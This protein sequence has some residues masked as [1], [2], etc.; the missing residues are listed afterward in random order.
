MGRI[1]SIRRNVRN[2]S[3]CTIH[4]DGD[5][6][7]ACALDVALALG[8]RV[9]ME[10]TPEIASTL[11]KEDARLVL[12]QKGWRYASYKPRTEQQVRDH[13]RK[14]DV[15]QQEIDDLIA[16]LKDF[17][18]IDDCGYAQRF[19]AASQ[20]R[21]PLSTADARRRLKA[22]GLDSDVIQAALDSRTMD[23]EIKAALHVAERKLR[24]LHGSDQRDK[25]VRFL[26]YRGF[27]WTV[28]R[29]VLETLTIT[30]VLLTVTSMAQA[31][32]CHRQRLHPSVNQWQP[33]AVPVL[34]PDGAVLYIDRKNHPDN[35]DG[36]ADNDDVWL[37]RRGPDGQWAAPTREAITS[38][39]PRPD[40]LFH[41]TQDNL[42]ALVVG[43]YGPSASRAVAILTRTSPQA[44][45]TVV[46]LVMPPNLSSIEGRF[47]GTMSDDGR[48]VIL[49]LGRGRV[50]F[51]GEA[52][53]LDLFVTQ[54]CSTAWSSLLEISALNSR[55]FEGAP[56]LAPDGQTLYFASSGREPKKGKADLYIVRK[57]G[58]SW[59]SWTS[60][61]W[62]G[63][64][65]NTG[66]DETALTLHPDNTKATIVSWDAESDQPG[67]YDV[68]LAL[69]HRPLPWCAVTGT[70][71]E[72]RSGDL[73]PTAVV[74]FDDGTTGCSS[75]V[76][77][78]VDD[79]AEFL[80][81]LP[82]KSSYTIR[83][84]APG[85]TESHQTLTLRT[86][87]STLA[88]RQ[89][90]RLFRSDE[91]LASLYFERGTSSVSDQHRSILRSL[92]DTFGLRNVGFA[93]TG[94]ADD[95]GRRPFN[96]T[97]SSKRA[98]A[99]KEACIELGI[100]ED[101][102]IAIG[103][104]VEVPNLLSAMRENPQSR[105]VDIFPITVARSPSA[106]QPKSGIRN[107]RPR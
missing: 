43:P 60:P 28:I 61:Q 86:L 102:L 51:K 25:L 35:T 18:L 84:E 12:R 7:S 3:R 55:G 77:L 42:R 47:Y 90:I 22:K 4:V 91:P 98:E 80:V 104:G 24:S 39:I 76:R 17:K 34:S 13:Y 53:D 75:P 57:V 65:V 62:L 29:H 31:Q 16:W 15:G 106:E 66:E 45:F 87:D 49:A 99:I 67:L 26:Q 82:Q 44:L 93:I 74:T 100:P 11:K 21:K 64:C 71:R 30:V 92:V 5:Y 36:S 54:R 32:Q 8:L 103:K 1:T 85:Y 37:S 10:L 59:L 63:P 6:F 41:V 73:L 9:G 78:P 107:R 89:T 33:T 58:S 52:D 97:L 27:S 105:R 94:Y 95:L 48:T 96:M 72:A 40:V 69:E 50:G 2:A 81:A 20:E 46:D 14:L 19:V 56:T 83:A 79:S 23:D 68:P 38:G 70:V 101:K 88:V